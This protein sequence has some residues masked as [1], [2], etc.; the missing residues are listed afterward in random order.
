MT[1]LSLLGDQDIKL[2]MLGS[3]SILRPR[4]QLDDQP[5]LNLFTCIVYV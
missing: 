3:S 1:K 2:A 4:Q 5:R